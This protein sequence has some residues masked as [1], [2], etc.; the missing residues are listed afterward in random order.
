M[1]RSPDKEFNSQVAT[2]PGVWQNRPRRLPGAENCELVEARTMSHDATSCSPADAAWPSTTATVGCRK[3]RSV[4]M[5]SVHAPNSSRSSGSE[6]ASTPDC[7]CRRNTSCK[8]CPEENHRPGSDSTTSTRASLVSGAI[9]SRSSCVACR[10]SPR[11]S[12]FVWRALV[13]V[14]RAMPVRASGPVNTTP[15]RRHI[16]GWGAALHCLLE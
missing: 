13:S 2:S 15:R 7:P 16:S 3:L 10:S 6:R 14:S 5:S 9:W 12:G 8:S 11:L 1:R 4:S